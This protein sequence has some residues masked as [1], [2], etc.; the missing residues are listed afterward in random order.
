MDEVCGAAMGQETVA[1]G[2]SRVLLVGLD[3]ATFAMLDPWIE[4]GLLP[5]LQKLISEGTR[6][7]LRSVIPPITGPAW[8]SFSTGVHPGKH[9]IFDFRKRVPGRPERQ[10][11]SALDVQVP[12]VWEMLAEAGFPVGLINLP[13]TYPPSDRTSFHLTDMLTPG[14]AA[15]FCHPPSLYEE[16]RPDLGEYLIDLPEGLKQGP[17]DVER[18]L[19]AFTECTRQRTRYTEHLLRTRPWKVATVVFVSLDRIQH[20]LWDILSDEFVVFRRNAETIKLKEQAERYVTLLDDCVGRVLAAAPPDTDVLIVSDHGFGPLRKQLKINQWLARHGLLVPSRRRGKIGRLLVAAGVLRLRQRMRPMLARLRSLRARAPK[21]ATKTRAYSPS[22]TELRPFWRWI[23]WAKTRAYA[24]SITEMG[25]YV[26]LQGRE[27]YGSVPPEEY[28]QVRDEIIA[29]L[30]ELS[31]PQT[32]KPMFVHAVRREEV[33][34]GGHCDRAPDV[35]FALRNGE[36][37]VDVRL[38]GPL[39]EPASW[40]AW[41]GTHR[42]DGIFIARGPRIRGG[43]PLAKAEIVDI[44][45]TVLHL[46]GLVAPSHMDGR[47]LTELFVDGVPPPTQAVPESSVSRVGAETLYSEEETREVEA[48]LRD[49]GYL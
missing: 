13:V 42:L 43:A 27:V 38:E 23:N 37:T 25:V 19:E 24:A 12:T 11:I 22:V 32:G 28:E 7:P 16:L 8:V 2:G 40:T 9:G 1:E 17:G 4:R 49:L 47:A 36:C 21:D 41:T 29:C 34:S 44:A 46:C 31:D 26:N 15:S 20:L 45:P 48:R 35:I 39:F 14:S 18:Y 30:Q 5:N 10:L 6:A 33:F 3:G